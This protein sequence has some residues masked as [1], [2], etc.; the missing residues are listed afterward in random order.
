M[1]AGGFT[2]HP[3]TDE[4]PCAG[5]AVCTDRRLSRH[6][7]WESWDDHLVTRWLHP[8]IDELRRGSSFLGGWL[9]RSHGRAWLEVVVVVP[10]DQLVFALHLASRAHQRAVYDLGTGTVVPVTVGAAIP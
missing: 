8:L 10:A 2:L 7:A 4:Q 5:F 1:H 3:E 9:E 6:I